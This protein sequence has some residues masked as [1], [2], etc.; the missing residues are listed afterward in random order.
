MIQVRA[1]AE[2]G[3]TRL[4]W[5]DGRHSFSFNRYYDPK[6]MGF[7][8]LRVIN[9]DLIAPAGG[10]G[11]HPHED[12]EILTWILEGSLAHKDSTG[13]TGTIS[14]GEAQR[15]SAGTGIFHS[16][17]NASQTEPVRLLQIWLLPE[18]E[19]LKPE[20]EQKQ[21]PLEERKNRLR[22]IASRDGRDGSTTMHQDATIYNAVLDAGAKV[23][24]AVEEGR[25]VWIQVATGSVLVNG[26]QLGEGDGAAIED[27]TQLSIEATTPGELLLFDLR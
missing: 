18:E 22:V 1:A 11:T 19:A 13:S 8:T 5:L 27:E 3:R 9:D 10:F 20:Y 15:M 17:F 16:E 23:E 21:F 4:G 14:P 25:G 24:H 6:H 2:R 12:M 7:R 26:V